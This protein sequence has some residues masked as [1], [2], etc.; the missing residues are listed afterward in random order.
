MHPVVF[1]FKENNK[2]VLLKLN[3][4][5]ISRTNVISGSRREADEISASLGNYTAYSDN[6]L[7]TFRNKLSV[8]SS[9]TKNYFWIFDP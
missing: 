4:T 8:P 3:K 2:N 7:P 6:S 1:V 5:Q 9:R